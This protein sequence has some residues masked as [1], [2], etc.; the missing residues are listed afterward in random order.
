MQC[1]C[2]NKRG[3]GVRCNA[4]LTKNYTQCL[5]HRTWGCYEPVVFLPTFQQVLQFVSTERTSLKRVRAGLRLRARTNNNTQPTRPKYVIVSIEL[6]DHQNYYCWNITIGSTVFLQEAELQHIQTEIRTGLPS[7]AF[8][9]LQK[10]IGILCDITPPSVLRSGRSR[11]A[12][13]YGFA[14]R[15]LLK[16][17]TRNIVLFQSN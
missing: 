1:P 9:V 10:N 3:V 13:N 8:A 4:T 16:T 17:C 14:Y 7:G 5:A 11:N 12:N 6:S 2:T 15:L